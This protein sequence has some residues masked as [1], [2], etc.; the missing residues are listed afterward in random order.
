MTVFVA[1]AFAVVMIAMLIELIISTRHESRLRARG[2]VEPTGDPHPVMR[3]AYPGSFVAMTV[4]G[5]LRGVPLDW[6]TGAALVLFLTAK[7]LKYWAMATL[8]ER[9]SFRVL[10]LPGA[11]LIASGPYTW[12]NHPNYVGVLG[13]VAAFGLLMRAPVTGALAM[14]C[15]I[16]LLRWRIRIEERALHRG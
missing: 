1:V 3:W 13:E 4:E 10:V 9:W 16:W 6:V 12:V 15:W 14:V 8:G 2:A 11:P 7:A 5:A